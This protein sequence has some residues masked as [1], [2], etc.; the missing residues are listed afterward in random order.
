MDDCRAVAAIPDVVAL[1]AGRQADRAVSEPEG[2]MMWMV[3][4]LP[5]D[6]GHRPTAGERLAAGSIDRI[7]VRQVTPAVGLA[8]GAILGEGLAVDDDQ[9]ALTAA[10]REFDHRFA[11]RRER[12]RGED[13]Q[14]KQRNGDTGGF[15]V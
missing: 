11:F 5:F 1:A 3:P 9:D 7:E 13:Q 6:L 10:F 15:E 2:A 12:R 14:A 4:L 8:A